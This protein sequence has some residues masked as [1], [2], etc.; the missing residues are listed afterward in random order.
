MLINSGLLVNIE[1]APACVT[2]LCNVSNIPAKK[3]KAQKEPRFSEKKAKLFWKG[4]SQKK[5]DE[6]EKKAYSIMLSSPNRLRRSDDVAG[7]M[8]GKGT[9]GGVCAVRCLENKLPESRFVFIISSRAIKKATDRNY[10]K[11]KA[12]EIVRKNL[13]RLKSGYDVAFVFYSTAK[14]LK[15]VDLERELLEILKSAR[16][17]R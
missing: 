14:G 16:L 15:Y 4:G 11:R 6:K 9:K 5:K 17:L 13:F 12:R 7:V 8:K 1:S 2:M 10:L 3:E